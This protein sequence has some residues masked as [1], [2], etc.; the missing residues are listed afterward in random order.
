MLCD[1]TRRSLLAVPLPA[2]GGPVVMRLCAVGHGDQRVSAGLRSR[3]SLAG[4]YQLSYRDGSLCTM[5]Q[6]DQPAHGPA[7]RSFPRNRT[8]N[9]RTK[10]WRPAIG[11]GRNRAP[12]RNRTGIPL[13]DVTARLKTIWGMVPRVRGHGKPEGQSLHQDLNP[14]PT[15]Y[16]TVAL[17]QLSYGGELYCEP[18]PGIE[19]G[20][21]RWQRDALPLS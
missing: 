8:S 21:S 13:A 1:P 19:P 3:I 7:P 18:H 16:K 20:S 9:S 4:L 14:E 15:V 10:V 6:G 17:D 12:C 5:S 11:L 2:S